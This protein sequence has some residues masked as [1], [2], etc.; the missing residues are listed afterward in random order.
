MW[1][2][3]PPPLL[4]GRAASTVDSLRLLWEEPALAATISFDPREKSTDLHR[5]CQAA[6][7]RTQAKRCA[8]AVAVSPS[9]AWPQ[10]LHANIGSAL[11]ARATRLPHESHV[12]EG[13]IPMTGLAKQSAACQEPH[14]GQSWPSGRISSMSRKPRR[15]ARLARTR[16]G[17]S[18]LSL[19]LYLYFYVYVY[20]G[21]VWGTLP[22]CV[23]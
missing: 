16:G 23:G 10:V 4:W 15:L 9:K 6:I 13:E 19:S 3:L 7:S 22:P 1:A 8:R 11:P 2:P 18:S 20:L 17:F 5:A 21:Y 14:R 12:P